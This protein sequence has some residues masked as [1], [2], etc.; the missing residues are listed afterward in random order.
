MTGGYQTQSVYSFNNIPSQAEV[1][2]FAISKVNGKVIAGKTSYFKLN[3]LSNY[4]L[5]L[6]EIVPQELDSIINSL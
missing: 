1:A 3:D 6:R 4:E 2:L 5:A